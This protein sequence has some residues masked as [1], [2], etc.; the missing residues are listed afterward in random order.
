MARGTNSAAVRKGSQPFNTFEA[1]F[2][3]VSQEVT[4]G[5]GSLVPTNP[6]TVGI[7]VVRLTPTVACHV[8][9]GQATPSAPTA[10]ADG[11][12]MYLPANIPTLVGV[13]DGDT[14]AVIQASDAGTLYITEGALS[15]V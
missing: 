1:I 9:I 12:C 7:S 14:V 11:S 5:S 2:Q 13:T 8:K 10:A 3:G 4:I 6:F 15:P